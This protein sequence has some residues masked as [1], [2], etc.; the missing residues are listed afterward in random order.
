[1]RR[2]GFALALGAALVA[3]TACAKRAAGTQ[4]TTP[5]AQGSVA[6]RGPGEGRGGRGRGGPREDMMLRGITLTADQQSR[7]DS[8][9]QKYRAQRQALDP[10]NNP[11]DRQKM[12]DLM[13]QQSDEIRAVLTADQQKVYDQNVAEMRQRMQER[14]GGPGGGP[15]Q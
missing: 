6:E 11:D 4:D 1:M 14:R 7:V 2:S 12:M 8:I 13:R 10:R 5:T 15:P 3:G 9:R